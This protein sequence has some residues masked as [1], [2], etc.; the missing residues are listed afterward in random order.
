MLPRTL[1]LPPAGENAALWCNVCYIDGD[2]TREEFWKTS[3]ASDVYIDNRRRLSHDNGRTWSAPESIEGDVI[4]NLPGGGIV[5]F[6][7]GSH[8]DTHF[9]TLYHRR[10]RRIWPGTAPYTFDWKTGEH[11]FND[12]VFVIEDD[13]PEKLLKYEEGPDYDPENPFDPAFC[14]TNRAY[15]GQRIVFAEDGTAY[16]PVIC[17]RPGADYNFRRGGV[18]LMR[19]DPATGAWSASTRQY[20]DPELSSRGLL[21]PDATVLKDG[22]I[23]VVCRGSNTDTTPGR[24]WFCVSTDGGATLS[25]VEEFRYDDGD[26]FYSPSSI[27]YFARS[28]KNGKLYWLANIVPGPPEGNGPRYPFYIAEIDEDKVTVRKDSLVMV[29]DRRENEPEAVQLSNFCVLEDRETLDMEIY[30]TRIGEDPDHF[31]KSGV[32]RY[33]FSVA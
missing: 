21:E 30:M 7:R 4:Q 28:T 23:L 1:Y 10:M 6:P 3:G 15:A 33:V 26:R 14:T 18:V 29:D 11:P 31:W 17:Y 27:H 9:G 24:K 2:L 20:I 8:Y 12:H 22:R 25:P 5:T 16:F 32:Y 13:G 19:R